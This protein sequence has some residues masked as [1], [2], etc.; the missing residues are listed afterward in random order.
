MLD[1]VVIIFVKLSVVS[2]ALHHHLRGR[3]GSA[4]RAPVVLEETEVDGDSQTF[5]RSLTKG[6]ELLPFS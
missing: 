6:K 4:H 1:Y 5:T 3:Q 2:C